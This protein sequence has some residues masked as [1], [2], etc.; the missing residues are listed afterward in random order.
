MNSLRGSTSSPISMVED[1][2]GLD[3]VFDLDA[4]EAADGGVHGRL[5]QLL[6]GSFAEAL[7][8]AG[9]RRCLRLVA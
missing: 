3:G 6:R 4:Q 7:G 2:V 8:S 5:P 9:G 1:L